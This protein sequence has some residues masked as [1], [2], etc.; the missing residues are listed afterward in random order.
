MLILHSSV[1]IGALTPRLITARKRSWG[2][3]IF[4]EACVILSTGGECLT[5]CTTHPPRT[6][7]TPPEQIPPDQTPPP[8]GSGTHP[9]GAD[10][11][12]RDQVHTPLE[13]TP[14]GTRYTPPEQSVLGDTVNVRAVR[15]LLE[16]IL[17]RS[18]IEKVQLSM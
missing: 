10:S 8:L 9:P 11:P 2:K 5:R 4:S 12:P 14:P 13:Q 15:I 7:H 18:S 6:R 16:C 17:V 3:V 1:K